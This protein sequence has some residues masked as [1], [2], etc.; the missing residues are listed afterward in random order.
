METFDSFMI[1]TLDYQSDKSVLDALRD[2]QVQAIDVLFQRYGFK[3]Y[4]LAYKMLADAEEAEAMTQEVF[5][6]LLLTDAWQPDKEA[7]DSFLMTLT[8]SRAFTQIKR[9]GWIYA[10]AKQLSHWFPWKPRQPALTSSQLMLEEWH[11]EHRDN[12]AAAKQF[13]GH[14][15][16]RDLDILELAYCEVSHSQKL[17]KRLHLPPKIAKHRSRKALIKLHH[18]R[19]R[20]V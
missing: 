16:Q 1:V 4:S 8:R 14:L 13:L 5:A 11:L 19:I 20:A 17:A 12:T 10:I 3:V 2:G 6:E 18:T 15:P 9:R 7:M